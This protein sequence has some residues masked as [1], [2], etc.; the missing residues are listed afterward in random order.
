MTILFDINHPAH[1]HYFKNVIYELKK[2]G[3]EVL[4]V[5]RNKE[6]EHELLQKYDIDFFNRGKGSSTF[7]GRFF[8]HIYAVLF[9]AKLILLKKADL[10]VSFMHPY[11]VHAA[12]LT[13]RPSIVLSDTENATLHHF[14]TT[15]FATEIHTPFT[16]T[17]ELG[18]R[19]HRFNSFMELAYLNEKNFVP[20][21][22]TLEA[23]GVS[24]NEKFILI[25]FVSRKALHDR[26]HS[27]VSFSDKLNLVRSLSDYAKVFISSEIELPDE[28]KP[29]ELSIDKALIHQVLYYAD[30]FIGES[31]TMAAESALLGTSAI[32][33][34]NEGRGYTDYL[35]KIYGIVF[36]YEESISGLSKAIAKANR[37]ILNKDDNQKEIRENII[38]TY[39]NTDEYIYQQIENRR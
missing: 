1:V 38:K 32:Y 30:L 3:D 24:N 31:A 34:D 16:F 22:N 8:Y 20:D 6:I 27:G 13:G 12:W 15:P 23:L 25:R 10:I 37:I 39:L 7:L 9:I 29:F 14:F 5:A 4:V 36:Q 11:G 35:S 17:K 2:R 21:Q 19:H 26:G 18:S 33:I 28:L